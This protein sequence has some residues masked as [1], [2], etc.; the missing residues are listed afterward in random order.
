MY[1][2]HVQTM[3]FFPQS[4]TTWCNIEESQGCVEAHPWEKTTTLFFCRFLFWLKILKEMK[5]KFTS[6]EIFACKILVCTI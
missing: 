5:Q 3:G 6:K 4:F 2:K 1:A